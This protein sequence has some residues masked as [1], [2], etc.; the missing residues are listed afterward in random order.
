VG[1]QRECFPAQ[2]VSDPDSIGDEL[3]SGVGFNIRRFVA[4]AVSGL[5]RHGD[6]VAS[7][8]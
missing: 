4:S 6:L 3:P 1:D 2:R 8:N 5:I 7:G